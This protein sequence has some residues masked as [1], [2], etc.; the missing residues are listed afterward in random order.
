M[1]IILLLK[2]HLLCLEALRATSEDQPSAV[3]ET[4]VSTSAFDARQDGE[5]ARGEAL[6]KKAAEGHE[7]LQLLRR[8]AAELRGSI[9]FQGKALDGRHAQRRGGGK[10]AEEGRRKKVQIGF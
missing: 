2:T 8:V 6:L 7:A 4:E 5:E 1:Q 3:A 9:A 10:T